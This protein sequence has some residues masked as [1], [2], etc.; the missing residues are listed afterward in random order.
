MKKVAE[1]F[2]TALLVL[3]M[4][5]AVLT[6][7]APHFGWSVDAVFSGSMEPELKV[8][9]VVVT[10]PVEAAEIKVGDI[11][12]FYPPLSEQLTSHRVIEIKEGSELS[13]QTKGDANEDPDPFIVPA[14]NVVGKICFHIPYLGYFSQAVKTRLGFL[15]A[16][17]IP[18]L[19]IIIMELKNIW[20]A[21]TEEETEKKYRIKG[22]EDEFKVKRSLH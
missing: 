19:I 14:Q 4:V 11:L 20:Q 15:L 13:F 5:S 10:R 17:G 16:L 22:P 8:G 12:T 6:F 2:G 7:L 9:G 1:G 18:A 3:V 21:L